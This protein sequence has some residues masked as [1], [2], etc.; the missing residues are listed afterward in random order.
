MGFWDFWGLRNVAGFRLSRVHWVLVCWFSCFQ[1]TKFWNTQCFKHAMDY[2]VALQQTWLLVS[3]Q[4]QQTIYNPHAAYHGYTGACSPRVIPIELDIIPR[5]QALNRAW[6]LF[7]QQTRGS[8][9]CRRHK[10]PGACVKH[11][12]YGLNSLKWFI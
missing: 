8:R 3:R 1:T 6:L 12:S 9:N 5:R 4:A 11:M 2:T 7:P 10:G